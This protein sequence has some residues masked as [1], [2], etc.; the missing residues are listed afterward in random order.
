LGAT[1]K[2][3]AVERIADIGKQLEAATE[4]RDKEKKQLE[5]W[6]EFFTE[7]VM[8]RRKQILEEKELAVKT[9]EAQLIEQL[10]I[11]KKYDAEED[12]YRAERNLAKA[13]ITNQEMRT[14]HG[15]VK[16]LLEIQQKGLDAELLQLM[17]ANGKGF[18]ERQKVLLAQGE[19]DKFYRD[20]RIKD[21]E[22]E[23][24][25]KFAVASQAAGSLSALAAS[26]SAEGGKNAEKAFKV[27]KALAIVQATID[28]ISGA[29]AAFA[30]TAGGIVIKG[31]AAAAAT[32]A[33][34]AR[35]NQI[36]KQQ[37]NS[38]SSPTN[39][40]TAAPSLGGTNVG[41]NVPNGFD[42]QSTNLGGFS[43]PNQN[44]G[45][46]SNG[47]SR[48]IVVERDIRNVANRVNSTERFA[49]FG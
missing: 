4:A 15:V 35:V 21:A 36:R 38:P 34:I 12:V 2:Q 20:L 28:T 19:L 49:T 5:E 43:Q 41:G 39:V 18:E 22:A 16:E 45:G 25:A 27:S 30:Q 11:I 6:G 17:D 8:I 23:E 9:L 29:Q 1:E 26:I 42:P 31:I 44:G 33:G 37:F 47:N 10:A 24:A 46:G 14:E 3:I 7:K 48:V 32:V 40:P 13:E